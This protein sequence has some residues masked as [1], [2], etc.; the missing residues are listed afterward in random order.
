MKHTEINKQTE[1]RQTKYTKSLQITNV[2]TL[3]YVQYIGPYIQVR[4]MITSLHTF[5]HRLKTH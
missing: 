2:H 5:C 1:I 3:H 4:V